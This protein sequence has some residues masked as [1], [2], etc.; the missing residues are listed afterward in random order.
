MNKYSFWLLGS[1]DRLLYG[2]VAWC[3]NISVHVSPVQGGIP[4]GI[5]L[6]LLVVASCSAAIKGGAQELA[7]ACSSPQKPFLS[8]AASVPMGELIREDREVSVGGSKEPPSLQLRLR[9]LRRF[10]HKATLHKGCQPAL[11][12]PEMVNRQPQG[13]RAA[14]G[15]V[16]GAERGVPRAEGACP[17]RRGRARAGGA[18]PGRSGAC[19]EAPWQARWLPRGGFRG[20]RWRRV[21]RWALR[22]VALPAGVPCGAVPTRQDSLGRLQPASLLQRGDSGLAAG[23]CAT[24]PPPRLAL[25]RPCW[26]PARRGG[27][28]APEDVL[29]FRRRKD[30]PAQV[31]RRVSRPRVTAFPPRPVRGMLA[32]RPSLSPAGADYREVLEFA[33]GPGRPRTLEPSFR[34]LRQQRIYAF[35]SLF[36]VTGRDS[37]LHYL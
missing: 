18:C 34:R 6:T 35:S 5:L 29:L 25:S 7:Q 4:G 19:W 20:G 12:Q 33:L 28:G 36:D 23:A 24:W 26:A 17:G 16:H 1:C 15:G 30:R 10:I 27:D 11:E 3:K 31:P 32:L 13:E 8:L 14:G 22:E 21:P 9:G 37:T 2:S